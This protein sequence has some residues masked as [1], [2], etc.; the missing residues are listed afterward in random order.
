MEVYVT[1][2]K[3]NN[4]KYIG[5]LIS[6]GPHYL[7]SGVHLTRAIKKYGKDNFERI[8]LEKVDSKELLAERER[9]WI[10]YYD[11]VNSTEYYNMKEGGDGGWD[12]LTKDVI[13]KRTEERYGKV[14]TPPDKAVIGKLLKKYKINDEFVGTKKECLEYLQMDNS[15]FHRYLNGKTSGYKWKDLK[16]VCLTNITYLI[17]GKSYSNYSEIQDD[18]D[19]SIGMINHNLNNKRKDWWKILD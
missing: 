3:L 19:I 6:K 8:T 9:Y 4:K 17:E 11:A 18:Y 5:K 10:E 13:D 16:V 2:N 14:L 12:H 15:T 1:V 7:G